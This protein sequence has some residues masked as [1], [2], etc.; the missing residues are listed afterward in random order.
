MA[1][2]CFT[3]YLDGVDSTVVPL[4]LEARSSTGDTQVAIPLTILLEN[5]SF[6]PGKV[7]LPVLSIS[8]AENASI[9]STDTY[10]N[11]SVSIADSTNPSNIYSG[12]GKIKGHGNTTWLQPKKPYKIKLDSKASILGMKS[13]KDWILLSNYDSKSMLR[14]SLAFHISEIMGMFG[15]P[16][17]QFAEVFLNGNYEGTY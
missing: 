14:T 13:A 10:V 15:T 5:P 12:T 4:T 7:D 6:S 17:T 3:G 16:S 11:A 2:S 8:T 9:T 1:T